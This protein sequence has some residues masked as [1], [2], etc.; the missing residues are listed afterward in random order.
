MQQLQK[1]VRL[2]RPYQ[3]N[4]VYLFLH[5]NLLSFFI[6]L[7]DLICK[8]FQ[9]LNRLGPVV[10]DASSFR[11][12]GTSSGHYVASVYRFLVPAK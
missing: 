3:A 10:R 8:V 4:L 9:F 7:V 6:L 12:T 5:F 1:F 11:V 2:G